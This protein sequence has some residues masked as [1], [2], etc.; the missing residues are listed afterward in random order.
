[1]ILLL[2]YDSSNG[3]YSSLIL[4]NKDPGM[5]VILVITVDVQY[6]KHSLELKGEVSQL[7]YMPWPS[8]LGLLRVSSPVTHQENELQI[9]PDVCDVVRWPGSA[10]VG[11][12]YNSFRHQCIN[13]C[14]NVTSSQSIFYLLPPPPP[15]V[16]LSLWCVLL[17]VASSSLS[18]TWLSPRHLLLTILSTPA[19]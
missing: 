2:M 13:V 11:T 15:P 17:G 10:V 6:Y 8:Y 9:A 19:E 3:G 7:W 16:C 5:N 14:V 4:F 12:L 1:M 18:L